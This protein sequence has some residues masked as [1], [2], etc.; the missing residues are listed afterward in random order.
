MIHWGQ[1]DNARKYIQLAPIPRKLHL[2]RAGESPVRVR[3][4]ACRA[5]HIPLGKVFH[6]WEA[7]GGAF[8]LRSFSGAAG[9]VA[10]RRNRHSR[11][12][13]P[14]PPLTAADCRGPLPPGGQTYSR[15]KFPPCASAGFAQRFS[16]SCIL[17]QNRPCTYNGL[18][19]G[20]DHK[21]LLQGH[22]AQASTLQARIS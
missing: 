7:G 11:I 9:D 1:V 2:W 13:Q 10:I 12:T 3:P 6:F 17:S 20:R 4:A 21:R 14:L 22:R 19:K 18:D 16:E 5:H 8:P 15:I